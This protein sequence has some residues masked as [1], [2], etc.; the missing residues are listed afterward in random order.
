MIE[1]P[2][3]LSVLNVYAPQTPRNSPVRAQN[4]PSCRHFSNATEQ[5][6]T[7][8]FFPTEDFSKFISRVSLSDSIG[9]TGWMPWF[10]TS[11]QSGRGFLFL[12]P[13]RNQQ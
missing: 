13:T 10:R 8:V 5:L 3:L 6:E 2:T 4:T 7:Q 1:N 12:S 11:L 9:M